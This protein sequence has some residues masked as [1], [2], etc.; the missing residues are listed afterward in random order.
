MKPLTFLLLAAGLGAMVTA[1]VAGTT[2]QPAPATTSSQS[3]TGV[4]TATQAGA[5]PQPSSTRN[6]PR[7]RFYAHS[8][9]YGVGPNNDSR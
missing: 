3:T 9:P 7:T 6:A 1:A 8:Q 4:D 5:A 2:K